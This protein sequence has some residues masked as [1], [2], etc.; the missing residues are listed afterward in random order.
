[1]CPY[2]MTANADRTFPHP[3]TETDHLVPTVHPAF[4]QAGGLHFSASG[5]EV[6][7]VG[8]DKNPHV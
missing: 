2:L 4:D 1:M 5:D 6:G 8:N 3:S 7:Q